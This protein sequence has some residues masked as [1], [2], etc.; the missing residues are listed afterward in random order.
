MGTKI[1]VKRYGGGESKYCT[2]VKKNKC[3][4]II[5]EKKS[6]EVGGGVTSLE[7]QRGKGEKESGM[8][9]GGVGNLI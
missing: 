2:N 6:R 5:V 3:P 1:K 4:Y 9:A 7:K 8:N